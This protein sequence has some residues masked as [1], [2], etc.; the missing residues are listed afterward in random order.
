[1]RR[2]LPAIRAPRGPTASRSRRGATERTSERPQPPP[3]RARGAGLARLPR[4][5]SS[6]PPPPPPLPSSR[7]G[8]TRLRQSRRTSPERLDLNIRYPLA[9]GVVGGE[10]VSGYRGSVPSTRRRLRG[11]QPHMK[12]CRGAPCRLRT[13]CRRRGTAGLQ[14]EGARAW[15]GRA[16]ARAEP[17]SARDQ[18]ATWIAMGPGLLN[19]SCPGTLGKPPAKRC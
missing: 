3:S 12:L 14:H 9:P 6:S 5:P 1:M 15:P 13:A 7:S 10:A 8:T 17:Q 18:R 19:S 4:L 16:H 2:R 11:P